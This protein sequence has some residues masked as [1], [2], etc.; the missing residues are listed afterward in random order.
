[1]AAD[2]PTVR[3]RLIV[4]QPGS[5]GRILFDGNALPLLVTDDRHTAE[6]DYINAFV[7][8]RFGLSTVVLRSLE[9]S[10]ADESDGSF[11]RVHVLEVAG[12][13][14]SHELQWSRIDAGTL[15]DRADRE[16]LARWLGDRD[17]R[18]LDGRE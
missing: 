2:S 9:H 4:E 6:V 14:R 10:D 16:A 12:D 1:V 13:A 7:A 5:G 11:D 18:V 8:E 3:H 15:A 17:S